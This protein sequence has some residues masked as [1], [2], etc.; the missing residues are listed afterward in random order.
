MNVN[1]L[2]ECF[3]LWRIKNLSDVRKNVQIPREMDRTNVE[4]MIFVVPRFI[5]K[6]VKFYSLWNLV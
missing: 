4:N 5:Y 6:V 1:M 2:I 3:N